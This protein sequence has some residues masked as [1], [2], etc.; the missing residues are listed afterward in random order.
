MRLSPKDFLEHD[1]TAG[2]P[3]C[4]RLQRGDGTRKGHSE[5][6][7]QRME[8]CLKRSEEGQ[9]RKEREQSRKQG[10]LDREIAKE[11]E[12]LQKEAELAESRLKAEEDA[13]KLQLTADQKLDDEMTSN[14]GSGGVGEVASDAE[15][16]DKES[17]QDGQVRPT[18]RRSPLVTPQRMDDESPLRSRPGSPIDCRADIAP[19]T[20][21]QPRTRDDAQ[22]DSP[23]PKKDLKAP[24]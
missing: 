21:A 1:Y 9:L 11:D 8:E 10:E 16:S 20:P 17:L 23:S 5:A 3:G 22:F 12:R 15:M 6:C 4:I 18:D 14:R 13:R 7:R 19:R 2:C 24:E